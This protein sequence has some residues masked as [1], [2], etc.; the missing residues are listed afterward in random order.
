M[1]SAVGQ[2]LAWLWIAGSA[3]VLIFGL[4][5]LGARRSLL[6]L[7]LVVLA[8]LRFAGATLRAIV[9]L[10]VGRRRY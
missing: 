10:S 5:K 4:K 6:L 3:V 8:G 9:A 1:E 2:M 7:S